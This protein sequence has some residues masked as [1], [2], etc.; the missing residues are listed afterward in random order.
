MKTKNC[1][2]FQPFLF[3]FVLMACLNMLHPAHGRSEDQIFVS[4]DAQNQPLRKVLD[5]LT[6]LSGYSF[7]LQPANYSKPVT[8]HLKNV[9]LEQAILKILGKNINHV[10]IWK[11][12]EKKISIIIRE[13]AQKRK[14]YAPPS[15][16]EW[17]SLPA[18]VRK[19]LLSGQETRFEQMSN[20][21]DY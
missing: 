2:L 12:K 20:T 6:E 19:A 14:E 1:T 18:D 17:D 8:V 3:F 16:D 4:L 9:P 13:I 15:L 10:V 7:N 21:T 11:D 5:Q